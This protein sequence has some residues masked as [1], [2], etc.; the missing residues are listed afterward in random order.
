M[1]AQYFYGVDLASAGK[2]LNW[3]SAYQRIMQHSTP[4][5]LISGSGG[6]V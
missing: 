6:Y 1:F 2:K 5:C 4:Q 3:E